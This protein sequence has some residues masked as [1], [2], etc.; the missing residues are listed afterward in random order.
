MIRRLVRNWVE[1]GHRRQRE[2]DIR[3]L[4]PVILEGAQDMGHA[5]RAFALHAVESP[6]WRYLGPNGIHAELMK[7]PI[8]KDIP[9][10]STHSS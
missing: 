2:T 5:Y 9:W 10:S 8:S 4:W 1:A 7:L 3:D 6:H